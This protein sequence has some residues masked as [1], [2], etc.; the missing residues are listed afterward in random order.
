MAPGVKCS[1]MPD[2]STSSIDQEA[3]R[4]HVSRFIVLRIYDGGTSSRNASHDGFQVR[5]QFGFKPRNTHDT[6]NV[7]SSQASSKDRPLSSFHQD[8]PALLPFRSVHSRHCCSQSKCIE[9]SYLHGWNESA[10]ETWISELWPIQFL[11]RVF[12]KIFIKKSFFV[13][14][15]SWF[16]VYYNIMLYY[17]L[18]LE[19]GHFLH[20]SKKNLT[21][22]ENSGAPNTVRWKHSVV[23][24]S[25]NLRA[26]HLLKHQIDLSFYW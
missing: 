18:Q 19:H 4:K 26:F 8:Q 24:Q 16:Y 3:S 22:L 21:V 7:W 25:C 10:S 15:L 1:V 13:E 2:G 5:F 20:D 14:N 11:E 9:G 23:V 6:L 17:W 12:S